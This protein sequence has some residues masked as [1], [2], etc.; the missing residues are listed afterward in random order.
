MFFLFVV[1]VGEESD[2]EKVFTDLLLETLNYQ[3]WE[4]EVLLGSGGIGGAL[5]SALVQGV[6]WLISL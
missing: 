1:C 5:L 2:Y 6:E 3:D 4:L